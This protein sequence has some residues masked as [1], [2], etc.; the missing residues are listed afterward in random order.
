MKSSE[1]SDDPASERD[2]YNQQLWYEQELDKI[3]TEGDLALVKAQA[4]RQQIATVD[5][6]LQE[7]QRQLRDKKKR[8]AKLTLANAN[9][10]IVA[11]PA[12]LEQV[13]RRH[14][15]SQMEL[16]ERLKTT[17]SAKTTELHQMRQVI[18]EMRRQRLD[19]L[20]SEARIVEEIR[21]IEE[22]A[23]QTQSEVESLKEKASALREECAQL[24]SAFDAEKATFRVERQRLQLDLDR[25]AR[26]ERVAVKVK[27]LGRKFNVYHNIS[28]SRKK[29]EDRSR[30]KKMS[31]DQKT[32]SFEQKKAQLDRLVLETGVQNLNEFI[33]FY[34]TQEREKAELLR[35]IEAKSLTNSSLTEAIS[36][37]DEDVARLSGAG[38]IHTILDELQIGTGGSEMKK[39]ID[40]DEALI[41]RWTAESH[42][43]SDAL[44]SLRE[45]I[46]QLYLV[47]FPTERDDEAFDSTVNEI[48]MLRRI[49]SIEER[50]MHRILSKILSETETHGHSDTLERLQKLRG[51]NTTPHVSGSGRLTPQLISLQTT[52]VI[53]KAPSLY[54]DRNT[55]DSDEEDDVDVV[56]IHPED[57]RPQRRPPTPT[58]IASAPPFTPQT[59]PAKLSVVSHATATET[60]ATPANPMRHASLHLRKS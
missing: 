56:T 8:F 40:A 25:I 26:P 44:R 3:R 37:L 19:G 39:R 15:H 35:R 55:A 47:L 13:Q 24:Q 5:A 36:H 2:E 18:D 31:L 57:C 41:A 23:K 1:P 29:R 21:R 17:V 48:S 54:D 53:V 52:P 42:S 10:G 7:L 9:G 38:D 27:V 46:R 51:V 4:E 14:A 43:F 6:E 60:T 50:V 49:G 34:N 11:D 16:E 32:V 28:N 30:A 20:S 22:A 58:T 59:S 33:Q 45:P 12:T